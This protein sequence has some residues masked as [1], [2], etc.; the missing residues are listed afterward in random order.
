MRPSENTVATLAEPTKITLP[1]YSQ[2]N[3]CPTTMLAGADVKSTMRR[4]GQLLKANWP[5]AESCTDSI[6]TLVKF[7]AEATKL[8]PISVTD[9]L[10]TSRKP[11]LS[12]ARPA[13]RH[14]LFSPAGEV[15]VQ[16]GA[17]EVMT[18][19]SADVPAKAAMPIESAAVNP[20]PSVISSN[21]VQ[22]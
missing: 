3:A 14:G 17:E 1:S 22:F 19:S 16:A 10:R 11:P 2:L 8:A 21:C 9:G 7:C 4:F 6:T 13:R 18:F 5:I 20:L 15:M 12:P